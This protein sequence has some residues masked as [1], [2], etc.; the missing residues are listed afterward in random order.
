MPRY[1]GGICAL[2][3]AVLLQGC[4]GLDFS[5]DGKSV[6]VLTASGIAITPVDGGPLERIPDSGAGAMPLWSPDGRR[7]LFGREEGESRDLMVYETQSRATRKIGS[8]LGFPYAWREDGRR[9]AAAAR[10]QPN[11]H[12]IVWYDLA[13]NGVAQ[14][15]TVSLAPGLMVWLPDTDDIAYLSG[16]SNKS[17]LYTVESGEEKRITT[18]GD[19]LGFALAPSRKE[20]IWAR[21]GANLKYQLLSLYRYDLKS[22][23]VTRVNFPMRVGL[24][25]P[26]PR[27]APDSISYAAFSPSGDRIAVLT[28]FVTRQG[29]EERHYSAVYAMKLD[30]SEARLVRKSSGRST[31]DVL[32]PVWSRDGSRLGIYDLQDK[33]IVAA[34]FDAAGANGKRILA[35]AAK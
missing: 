26:D 22:R 31:P 34:V 24:I 30:G 27:R 28:G 10:P 25:N 12:E 16:S 23:S 1:F 6:A 13:E 32:W 18:T 4:V 5:P 9:I 8:G 17:D 3:L 2:A 29:S 15:T 35:E 19:L 14:R 21:R 20:L 33:Q 11:T 7:I